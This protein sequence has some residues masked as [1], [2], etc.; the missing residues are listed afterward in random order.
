VLV[1]RRDCENQREAK[2]MEN[3]IGLPLDVYFLF[4]SGLVGEQIVPSFGR[5]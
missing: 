3:R 1:S 2:L 5:D 4:F